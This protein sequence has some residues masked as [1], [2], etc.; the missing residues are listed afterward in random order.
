MPELKE[1]FENVFSANNKLYTK[2]LA[3]GQ[4]V[5]GEALLKSSGIEYREWVPWRSKLSAGIRQGLKELP[6]RKGSRVLY[7]GCAEGTT[8][9]HVSDIVESNGLVIGI[10]FSGKSMQKF[11]QLAETRTNIIPLLAD[12]NQPQEYEA[13]VKELKPD[14]LFQDVSQP[15]QSEIFAKNAGKFLA[16]GQ[17]A[18]IALKTQSIDVTKKPIEVI[19]NELKELI[20]H[21]DVLQTIN[22]EPFEKDHALIHCRKK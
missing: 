4:R 21:F 5:Y 3:P 22:L 7:L 6:I 1:I 12:A 18:L 8:V 15:N 2:N 19:E 13:D 11:I 14:V 9:S 20:K 17:H 10:D 16:E